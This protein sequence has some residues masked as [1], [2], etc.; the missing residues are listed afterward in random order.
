VAATVPQLSS[1]GEPR[2][3]R[4][5]E[6]LATLPILRT[7]QSFNGR[8]EDKRHIQSSCYDHNRETVISSAFCKQEAVLM[9]PI[10]GFEEVGRFARLARRRS[11]ILSRGT[12]RIFCSQH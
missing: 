11:Y 9:R 12:L 3:V 8:I 4:R 1:A 6:M 2:I 5:F 10:D 7:L